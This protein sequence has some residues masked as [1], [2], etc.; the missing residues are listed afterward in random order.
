MIWVHHSVADLMTTYVDT[1]QQVNEQR[2]DAHPLLD[3]DI[4]APL[5]ARFGHRNLH[6]SVYRRPE[7]M[8]SGQAASNT[9]RS[10]K[11]DR[12]LRGINLTQ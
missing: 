6:L 5:V 3:L 4:V 8:Y 1:W 10:T 2:M 12:T 11:R 9:N 7:V